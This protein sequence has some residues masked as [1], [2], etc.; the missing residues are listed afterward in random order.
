MADYHSPTIIQPSIPNVDMTP[1]ERLVLTNIFDFEPHGDA[2]YLF[3]ELE[4]SD[5]FEI[6]AKS[7]ARPSPHPLM[8]RAVFVIICG[9]H[10][11]ISMLRPS[12]SR[13]ISAACPGVSFYRILSGAHKHWA[14][15]TC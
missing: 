1:L 11:R 2:L 7:S 15:S 14:I 8:C 3:T 9:T 5:I 12:S 10:S 6:P 13:L 4:P